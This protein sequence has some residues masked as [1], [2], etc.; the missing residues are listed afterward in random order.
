MIYQNYLINNSICA[1][2]L[3]AVQN[4]KAVIA[5]FSSRQLLPALW[6]YREEQYFNI[7]CAL[8]NWFNNHIYYMYYAT[9]IIMSNFRVVFNS[10]IIVIVHINLIIYLS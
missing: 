7:A 9:T 3:T 4:Q 5:N 2:L 1:D 6:L 8:V 10:T